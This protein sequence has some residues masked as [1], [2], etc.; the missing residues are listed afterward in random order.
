MS[1]LTIKKKAKFF[2]DSTT[3]TFW[4]FFFP[5]FSYLISSIKSTCD[6]EVVQNIN[7]SNFEL[8][9]KLL[10][11]TFEF[12]NFGI[13][14][15]TLSWNMLFVWSLSSI[16]FLFTFKWAAWPSYNWAIFIYNISNSGA[17]G[18]LSFSMKFVYA[19]FLLF[20]NVYIFNY[21][22][23]FWNLVFIVIS[24]ASS[25]FVVLGAVN[26]RFIKKFLLYS[27]LGHVGFM[28]LG[29]IYFIS[30]GFEILFAYLIVFTL[31]S[32][33]SWIFIV[34]SLQNV[35]L[36]NSFVLFLKNNYVSKILLSLTLFAL[37]GL[38]PF[39]GF[40]IK[41]EMLLLAIYSS[42]YF[43]VVSLLLLSL[44]TLFY[45]IRIIKILLFDKFEKTYKVQFTEVVLNLIICFS[46]IS[47]IFFICFFDSNI[48]FYF[49]NSLINAF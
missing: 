47:I 13:N 43:L 29:F 35:K 18:F 40:F 49:K 7:I 22:D 20:L 32:N 23:I 41:F 37:S 42:D 11:Q 14:T 6:F 46:F 26:E 38:P 4:M 10:N 33:I 15:N 17:A 34:S 19:I 45:Y 24:I 1:F 30:G 28:L 12:L 8:I 25:T 48:I 39:G 36:L 2:I 9:E 3:Y 31:M 5:I 16:L 21:L 27:S 44:V